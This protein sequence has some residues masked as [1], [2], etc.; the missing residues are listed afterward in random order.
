MV[1]TEFQH[2]TFTSAQSIPHQ[3]RILQTSSRR[4]LGKYMTALFQPIAHHRG[5]HRIHGA[6][7]HNLRLLLIDAAFPIPIP[8]Y[9]II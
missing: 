9:I 2:L 1:E 5:N 4:L 3:K 8:I 7:R 6:Y